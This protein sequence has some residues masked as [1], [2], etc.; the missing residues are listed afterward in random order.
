MK[1]EQIKEIADRATEQL[2]AALNAGHSEALTGYLKAIGRFHRYSLH[3]VMLIASQKPNASYVA[4]FRT[5]NELGRFVKKGEKG[6]LILAP[7][8]RR[9]PEKDEENR[10]DV[11]ASIAGFR[12]AYVF[13][14]SQTDGK[15]LPQIDK[16]HGDPQ[17]HAGRL[18]NFAEA[19]GISVEYSEQ[20]AP[21][22][23]VSS[24]GKITLLPGQSP[25]EEFS[26]LAHE[27]AHEL[28]HRGDRR[29]ATSRRIR[30][31]EAEATAFVVCHAI[32]L[33]TGSAASDYIQLWNGDAQ[34]LTQSLAYIRHAASQMLAALTDE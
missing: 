29:S 11:S 10:D 18:R 20:I 17:Q 5:W 9:S 34:L 3:N 26:T 33:E 14:V 12:A 23:G 21:A 6:I 8:V 28:L 30:E 25:A 1:S 19:Q 31:T 15:E 27:I 22:R 24:G 16:V 7:I 32:S 13:D 4:G 2:T